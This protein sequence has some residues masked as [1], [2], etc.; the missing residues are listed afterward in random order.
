MAVLERLWD[1]DPKGGETAYQ[2]TLVKHH[3]MAQRMLFKGLAYTIPSKESICTTRSLLLGDADETLMR[4]VI[5]RDVGRAAQS[6]APVVRSAIA[7]NSAAG[8][9]KD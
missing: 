6:F 1:G 2:A 5:D 3:N 4:E 7:I 8:G 9:E